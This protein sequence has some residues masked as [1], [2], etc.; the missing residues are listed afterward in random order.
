MSTQL[1]IICLKGVFTNIVLIKDLIL[2]FETY[3]SDSKKTYFGIILTPKSPRQNTEEGPHRI[4]SA[5]LNSVKNQYSQTLKIPKE[6]HCQYFNGQCSAA[7]TV[8]AMILP[9]IKMRNG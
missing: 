9:Q 1:L 4:Q 3:L 2:Y 5:V 8:N 7:K 6:S